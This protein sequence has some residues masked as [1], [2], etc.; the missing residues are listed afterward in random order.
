[1]GIKVILFDMD[2][3]LIDRQRIFRE[4][5]TERIGGYHSNV[6]AE[7]LEE[8]V[9]QI[10][11]WDNCGNQSRIVTFQQ[12]VDTY[13]VDTTAKELN[14]YWDKNSGKFLH[15]F[16]DAAET[17]EYLHQN[18]R[19]G[20]VSNGNAESQRRKIAGLPFIDLFEYSI[21]SGEIGIHKPDKGIFLKVCEDMGVLPEECIFVGD[22][23]RCDIEGAL[24][25]GM[26]PIWISSKECH[27][28]DIVCIEHLAELKKIL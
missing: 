4:M 8:I 6:S 3:T 28:E 7:E 13:Q 9:N 1:M 5:L 2:N 10:V 11:E 26:K 20:I 24:Q 17:I 27:K 21:V 23:Y 18:Y 22:N 16:E 15:V 19:L 25:V 12:Y 14:D